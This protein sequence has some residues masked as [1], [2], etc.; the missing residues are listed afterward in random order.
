MDTIQEMLF[1]YAPNLMVHREAIEE[2]AYDDEMMRAFLE[3]LKLAYP[4]GQIVT[5]V[6]PGQP[7]KPTRKN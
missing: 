6:R 5:L 1:A 7:V 2:N 3:V 4:F